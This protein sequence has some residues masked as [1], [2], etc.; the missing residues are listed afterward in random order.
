MIYISLGLSYLFFRVVSSFEGK[1]FPIG[2]LRVK[3]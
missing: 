1:P 2:V 3:F